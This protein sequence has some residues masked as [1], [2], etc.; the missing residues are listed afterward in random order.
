MSEKTIDW[1]GTI[2]VP[3]ST[4]DLLTIRLQRMILSGEIPEGA[5]IPPERVLAE[6]LGVSRSSLRDALRLLEL[7]GLIE[8]K[9]GRGTT[10]LG[11]G[12]GRHANDIAFS[13]DGDVGDL[14]NVL[15]VRACVEPPVAAR[16]ASRATRVD[17]AQLRQLVNEMAPSLP[18]QEFVQL[19]WLFHRTIAQYTHN[20][21][22]LRL[23]DRVS[24]ITEVSRRESL[25]SRSRQRSSTQEH[26]EIFDAIAAHDPVAAF[27]AAQR[28]VESIQARLLK[29]DKK[30]ASELTSQHVRK[31]P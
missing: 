15:E 4:P 27:S 26:K 28:H 23:L 12:H 1:S 7:R 16:A 18:T 5:K 22:L 8:R 31:Q 21:L 3:L 13:L 19:D 6:Q 2:Q 20:P 29:R 17:V 30:P 11:A 25:V 14:A 9:Q 10:V 24:E